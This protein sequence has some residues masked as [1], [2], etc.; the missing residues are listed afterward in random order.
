MKEMTKR[1]FSRKI[2]CGDIAEESR[3]QMALINKCRKSHTNRDFDWR[4][5]DQEW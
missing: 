5:F 3:K 1:L 4:P 2:N